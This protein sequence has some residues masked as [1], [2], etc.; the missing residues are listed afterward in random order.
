MSSASQ[1]SV[2]V[3]KE[4]PAKVATIGWSLLILGLVLGGISFAMDSLRTQFVSI[5]LF[6]F[7]AGVGICALFMVAIEYVAS[8]VWSTPIR[9]V[10][11]IVA[12]LILF[13]PIFALP[14][15]LSMNKL[16]AWTHEVDAVLQ[17]KAG[18]LNMPFFLT[19][20]IVIL[21]A[22]I[23]FYIVFTKR[24]KAQDENKDQSLSAKNI[25]L[26]AGFIPFFGFSI[27]ALA[28][29]FMMSLEPHWFSTM[30]G[31]I[32]FA[33]SLVSSLAVITIAVVLLNENG[34]LAKGIIGDH[35][36]SLGF[37]MFAGTVFWM[38]TSFSQGMLIWYANLPEE[39]SWFVH[40]WQ[41]GWNVIT[42]A[43]LL[44]QFVIPFFGLIQR[45]NKRNPKR[46]LFMS[47]W[48]IFAHLFDLYWIVM[49]VY[50]DTIGKPGPSLGLAEFAGVAIAAGF[51]V[52]IFQQMS[53]GKNLVPI[54]DPKL[55]R[56]LEFRL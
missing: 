1:S 38:Y 43:L 28:F 20:V 23:L 29:D 56:G 10:M 16:Y 49:P 25:K 21:G 40:R 42:W 12:S 8:A 37:G 46:M 13:L 17:R 3:K 9:R 35:Y 30:F 41:H 15:I 55:Q 51:I 27:T 11:E 2:Y 50:G 24:S 45:K 19:R 26:A 22:W 14:V 31:V 33:G 5:I 7:L 18:Y 32:V 48:L 54:G 34:Y 39:T 44:V 36:Y 52:V 53:K 6:M 47:V 4:L